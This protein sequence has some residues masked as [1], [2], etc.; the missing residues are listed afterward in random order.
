MDKLG[1]PVPYLP[2]RADKQAAS[3][4]IAEGWAL[5]A[6]PAAKRQRVELRRE[7]AEPGSALAAKCKEYAALTEPAECARLDMVMAQERARLAREQAEAEAAIAADN[8]AV[9]PTQTATATATTDIPCMLNLQSTPAMSTLPAAE[10]MR[11]H[12]VCARL[13]AQQRQG[14]D[15]GGRRL[16]RGDSIATI[17]REWQYGGEY[18][19]VKSLLRESKSSGKLTWRGGG[20]GSAKQSARSELSKKELLPQAIHALIKQ[21]LPEQEAVRQVDELLLKFGITTIRAKFDAFLWRQQ[22]KSPKKG[23][24]PAKKGAHKLSTKDPDATVMA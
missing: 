22:M 9:Q 8:R 6:E 21:G 17:W 15:S 13:G 12:D 11:N 23:V 3:K 20:K 4:R 18:A 7:I 10:A 24:E 2:D 1:L 16:F 5:V 14:L 19:S